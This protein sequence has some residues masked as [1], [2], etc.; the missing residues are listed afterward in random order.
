[1]REGDVAAA[2]G[3]KR[4]K[5]NWSFDDNDVNRTRNLKDWNLTRYHCATSPDFG[6]GDFHP[7][8]QSMRD[9][10]K[11]LHMNYVFQAPS[12]VAT[13]RTHL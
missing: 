9:D 11:N 8:Y 3:K 1:M 13:V 12:T 6:L 10:P 2:R 5:K 4:E 7:Y